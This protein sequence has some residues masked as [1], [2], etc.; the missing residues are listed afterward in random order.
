MEA[1]QKMRGGD[2]PATLRDLILALVVLVALVLIFLAVVAPNMASPDPSARIRATELSIDRLTSAVVAY[3]RDCAQWPSDEHGLDALFTNRDAVAAWK[4]PYVREG[5][6]NDSWGW[7][8]RMVFEG[9]ARRLVSAG[10]DE[11]F[12]TKDDIRGK[13]FAE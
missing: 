5:Y 12:G 10:P 8:F 3:H 6:L 4:G 2:R 1:G 7:P 9:K 11:Q 13:A